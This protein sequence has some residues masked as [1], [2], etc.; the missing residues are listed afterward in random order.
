M[1]IG[2]YIK[3]DKYSINSKANVIGDELFGES[4]CK[5]IKKHFKDVQVE[6]YAPNYIPK[7]KLDL[8]VYLN[9]TI[10][11]S[12]YAN[13]NVFYL[14]NAYD[15]EEYK[16][17]VDRIVKNNYNG[18]I[19]FSKKIKDYYDANYNSPYS[20]YLPFGVDTDFFYPR[21]YDPRFDF[22]CAYIGNDIKGEERTMK[23]LYPAVDFNFGLFGN[24]KVQKARFKI[25]KNFKKTPFFKKTFEK[26]SKGKIMQEEVPKLYS[27]AK[28]NLNCTAQSCVDWDVV[29]LR[30]YEVLACK[31]FLISDMVPMAGQTMEDCIVFTKGDNDLKEKIRYYLKNKNERM[32][33]AQAGY[34]YIRDN[35]SIDK[36]A[37]ELM[38]YLR[39]L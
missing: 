21:A 20:L 23:F 7:E 26:I 12:E 28:I 35:A 18:F 13:K 32:K 30:T 38:E 4:I 11:K 1:K 9:E 6:L 16:V 8:M 27:S 33:I 25:W 29:T 34:D 10:I 3:F 39:G 15:K 22:D 36:R 19:F 5:S 2:F 31:G 14:Q 24:W 17:V 37:K